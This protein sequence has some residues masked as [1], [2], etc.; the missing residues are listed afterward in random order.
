MSPSLH[1]VG[2]K[3]IRTLGIAQR[4]RLFLLNWPLNKH[5]FNYYQNYRSNPQWTSPQSLD[6][7]TNFWGQMDNKVDGSVV[8]S[9]ES[10]WQHQCCSKETDNRRVDSDHLDLIGAQK[11]LT[12]EAKTQLSVFRALVG[13]G[14][15]YSLGGGLS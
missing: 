10:L 1:S 13:G 12:C 7:N 8:C 3:H 4:S 6:L 15:G 9:K 11:F 2:A 14:H 5:C